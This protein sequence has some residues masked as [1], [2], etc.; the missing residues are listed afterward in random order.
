MSLLIYITLDTIPSSG[1]STASSRH[2][3]KYGWLTLGKSHFPPTARACD[4]AQRR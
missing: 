4:K 1:Y 3:Q 2:P